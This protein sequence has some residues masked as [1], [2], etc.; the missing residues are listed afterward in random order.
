[1]D[2][3][4]QPFADTMGIDV[5]AVAVDFVE[6]PSAAVQLAAAGKA[7]A[8]SLQPTTLDFKLTELDDESDLELQ[9]SALT[10]DEATFEAVTERAIE[11]TADADV[12]GDTLGVDVLEAPE[13]ATVDGETSA[14][15]GLTAS[16]DEGLFSPFSDVMAAV[17]GMGGGAIAGMIIGIL[18]GVT[19]LVCLFLWWLGKRRGVN[20][21]ARCQNC[22]PTKQS[23][24]NTKQSLTNAATNIS[25]RLKGIGKGGK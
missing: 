16:S 10:A 13:V 1:M 8:R 24:A 18:L 5:G 7:S 17:S 23:L 14:T 2:S 3:L 19:G 20:Y 15:A 9:F 11:I 22:L 4:K 12:A 21:F 6:E 25:G